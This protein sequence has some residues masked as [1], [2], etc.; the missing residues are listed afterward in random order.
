MAIR[1][2]W[3]VVALFAVVLGVAVS[4][5]VAQPAVPP[6]SQAAPPGVD[7]ETGARPGNDIGTGESL[8]LSDKAGN[9]APGDTTSVLAPNLPSPTIGENATPHDYL[10][11]ARAALVLDQTG[12]AQQALEMA[13]TRV[14]DRSVPLFKTDVRI[15]DPLIGEIE[16]ALHALGEGDRAGAVQIIEA[17][18]PHAEQPVAQ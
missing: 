10:L 2:M 12:E 7:P 8:P 11:A 6:L 13:E 4:A 15:N 1:A 14:L 9:I 18:L 3:R 5:A 16:Q 17:A